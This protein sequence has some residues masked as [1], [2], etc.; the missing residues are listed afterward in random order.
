VTSRA[1]KTSLSAKP[2]QG[3]FT[4]HYADGCHYLFGWTGKVLRQLS[5][6]AL[7][8]HDFLSLWRAK[9]R[10]FLQAQ[11]DDVRRYGRARTIKARA[12]TFSGESRSCSFEFSKLAHPGWRN[13]AMGCRWWSPFHTDLP[14]HPI[15]HLILDADTA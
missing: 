4:L 12:I 8:D 14:S 5:G 10:V 7:R 3:A 1:L 9:G 13:A 15:R 6:R 2:A 11:L